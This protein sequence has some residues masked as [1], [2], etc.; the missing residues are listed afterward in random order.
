MNIPYF[1]L[2]NVSADLKS[3]WQNA[4][5]EIIDSGVFVGGPEL[6]KFEANWALFNDAG[7]SIGVGNGY[8]AIRI[9]LLALGVGP[10]DIVAV[11]VHTFIATWLAV[12][13]V[14]ATPFGIDINDSGQMDIGI[15]ESIEINF[16]L[17][18][19]VHMHGR[20]V[21]M[22]RLM[23]WAKKTQTLVV[24]DCAQAH[25]ATI[26]G[27]FV[28]TFGNIGCFSFY[29]TKNLGALGDGGALITNDSNL[30]KQIRSIANYGSN[31]TDKY[32]H[33]TLGLNSRLDSMQAS[34]LG[35][36]LRYLQEWNLKRK[37]IATQYLNSNES[38]S[39]QSQ[40]TIPSQV[41][42]HFTILVKGRADIIDY[43]NANGV[44][45]EIHYPRLASA[46]YE[47]LKGNSI[48]RHINGEFFSNHIL[49]IPNHPWLTQEEIQYIAD[50]LKRMEAMDVF[51]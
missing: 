19:P 45:T 32:H 4:C 42:H 50:L 22:P 47:K 1:S 18:I 24:E 3:E 2:R 6:Q 23:N 7:F 44:A 13:S 48:T 29:P 21:D 39:R 8:D 33:E 14:G 16:K 26:D 9:A 17:V 12:D 36:N 15:L 40:L 51:I 20:T 30:A 28:G 25:G 37:N 46:E 38:L 11:P 41:F 49:S 34:I 5:E 31:T 35:I 27:R 10:G 43:L